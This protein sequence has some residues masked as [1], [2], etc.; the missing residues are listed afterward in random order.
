MRYVI[1]HYIRIDCWTYQMFFVF[2]AE[3]TF[4]MTGT[5][6]LHLNRYSFT[7]LIAHTH[8]FFLIFSLSTFTVITIH[9]WNWCHCMVRDSDN[10]HR[11]AWLLLL[12]WIVWD[13]YCYW[14]SS[15]NRCMTSRK[16][17]LIYIAF[18]YSTVY[19]P[20]SCADTM[21]GPIQISVKY[22]ERGF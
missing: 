7:A 11:S 19:L 21:Y 15:F 2:L 20:A 1:L 10:L 4:A 8:N 12:I 3:E 9:V 16:P 22:V 17:S 13:F 18:A 6:F 14:R 5:V